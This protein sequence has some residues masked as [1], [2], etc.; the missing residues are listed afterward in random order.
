M[1][2]VHKRDSFVRAARNEEIRRKFDGTNYRRL[3]IEHNLSEAAVRY[4]VTDID[5][6]LRTQQ[7]EGQEAIS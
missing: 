7:I 5:K 1:I 6:D 2:Y 4:I 3:A